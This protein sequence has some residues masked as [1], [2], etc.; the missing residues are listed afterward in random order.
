MPISASRD[1]NVLTVSQ[2]NRLARGLLEDHFPAVTVQGEISNFAQPASGHW[3]LTLK[4]SAAQ[5]RCAMFRN[6]NMFVRFKPKDGMQV[7]V[8]A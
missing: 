1:N 5:V 7:T 2:L 8:K 6:R 4:D 3:Y